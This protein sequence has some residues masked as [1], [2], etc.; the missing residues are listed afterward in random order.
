M[1]GLMKVVIA[2]AMSLGMT[3]SLAA[4]A[5]ANDTGAFL[6]GLA[7]GAFA[8]AAIAGGAAPPPPPAAYRGRVYDEPV[9]YQRHCWY[10]AEPV[11][12]A[13]GYEVGT[14]TIKRCR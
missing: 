12:N 14:Q 4:P 7:V 9:F 5:S 3:A 2:A 8:G 6:G 1:T 10:E 11:Y 13:A